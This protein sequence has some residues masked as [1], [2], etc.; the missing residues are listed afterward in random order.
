VGFLLW[1]ESTGLADWV[2]MSSIGYPMMITCHA[3]GMA[4]MVGLS[5]MLDFRLLGRFQGIPYPTLQR[6]LGIAWVGFG[7]NFLSGVALFT[8]QAT[9][10]VTDAMFLI[11]I[12][13]VLAGA[14][15]AALLQ[16]AVTR[17]SPKWTAS[18]VP[19]SVKSI[20]ILSLVCWVGATITG[21]LIA[22]L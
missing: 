7:I 17:D 18:A 2:R 16:T 8:T 21:R 6:F 9:T 20:A 1:L 4:V 12:A 5:M 19:G 14:V 3:V 10:Y 11:K 13:L 22:Y 15:T